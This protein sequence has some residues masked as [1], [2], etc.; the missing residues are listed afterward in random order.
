[1]G[2]IKYIRHSKETEFNHNVSMLKFVKKFFIVTGLL[3]LILL[4]LAGILYHFHFAPKVDQYLTATIQR[5][6][7]E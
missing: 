2:V 7:E 4:V 5:T 3:L 6:L 1:M